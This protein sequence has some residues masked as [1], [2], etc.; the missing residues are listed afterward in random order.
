MV[1]EF[2]NNNGLYLRIQEFEEVQSFLPATAKVSLS[3][4]SLQSLRR[5]GK[6]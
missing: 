6:Q 2:R 3:L 5:S 1:Y 4:I